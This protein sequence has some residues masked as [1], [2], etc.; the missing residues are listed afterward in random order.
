MFYYLQDHVANAILL[1]TENV[2]LINNIKAGILDCHVYS[3]A[4]RNETVDI[5][6]QYND[7]N[8]GIKLAGLGVSEFSLDEF[9]DV[10]RKQELVNIRKPAFELLLNCADNAIAKNQYGFNDHDIEYIQHALKSSTAIAE[11]ATVMKLNPEFAKEE[12]SMIVD[13]VFQDRFRIFTV[14]NMWK[15]QINKCVTIDEIR[16]VMSLIKDSFVFAG[17]PNV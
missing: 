6:E 10:K 11:Y 13:S 3:F 16:N 1:I 7:S 5:I 8:R 15:E 14:C 9:P 2:F 12:L 17:M 4:H